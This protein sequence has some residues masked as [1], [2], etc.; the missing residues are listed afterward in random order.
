[1]KLEK[2]RGNVGKV[3]K[4]KKGGRR[5]R[6]LEREKGRA[7]EWRLRKGGGMGS[8]L[9]RKEKESWSGE[10]EKVVS[11]VCVRR[12]REREAGGEDSR[13]NMLLCKERR[14]VWRKEGEF[15]PYTRFA[16]CLQ[17]HTFYQEHSPPFPA[18]SCTTTIIAVPPAEVSCVKNLH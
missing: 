16:E 14:G 18:S 4:W 11:E 6:E 7:R 10:G 9:N 2:E 15:S 5:C 1:M 3:Y 17:L 12:E 13:E 8:L